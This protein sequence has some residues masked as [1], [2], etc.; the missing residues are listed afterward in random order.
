MSW[1][2]CF[3]GSRCG[4]ACTQQV[5]RRSQHLFVSQGQAAQVVQEG[6]PLLDGACQAGCSLRQTTRDDNCIES[7]VS[8]TTGAGKDQQWSFPVR[9]PLRGLAVHGSAQLRQGRR[10]GE[11]PLQFMDTTALDTCP[12]HPTQGLTAHRV[13][14]PRHS[15][16][17][18][19]QGLH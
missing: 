17:D 1:Q 19:L 18:S 3:G 13:T 16:Q 8:P 10:V 6:V 2:A 15:S 12:S 7:M 14:A 9:G 11:R 4:G 5:W